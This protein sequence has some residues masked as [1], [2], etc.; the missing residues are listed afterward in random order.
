MKVDEAQ[1]ASTI[2]TK[3][4]RR[5]LLLPIGLVVLLVAAV[6]AV[7]WWTVGRFVE[8]TD[9]AYLQADSVTVASK[10]SGYVT[11]VFVADNQTVTPGQA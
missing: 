3:V 8:S 9:D 6:W 10:V 11:E 2:A 1:Q 7:R 4:R 5:T